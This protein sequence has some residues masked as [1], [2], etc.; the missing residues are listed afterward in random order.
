MLIA[1]EA[2]V[3]ITDAGT[4]LPLDGPLDCTTPLAWA[5][6]ANPTLR[7][8]IEPLLRTFLQELG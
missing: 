2:G 3:I 4:G 7:L 5:G 8:R 6:Y 1:E